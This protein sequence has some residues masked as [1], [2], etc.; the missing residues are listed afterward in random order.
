MR[1]LLGCEGIV[2]RQAA[3]GRPGR[4]LEADQAVEMWIRPWA[5]GRTAAAKGPGLRR[6]RMEQMLSLPSDLKEEAHLME[7]ESMGFTIVSVAPSRQPAWPS[8]LPLTDHGSDFAT[9]VRV[10]MMRDA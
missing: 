9:C 7:L 2:A 10:I 1:W 5:V 4:W 3:T 8:A 6:R